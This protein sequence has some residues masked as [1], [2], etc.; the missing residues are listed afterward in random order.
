[1][2][3]NC[4]N[5]D[6]SRRLTVFNHA[7]GIAASTAMC[8]S[9]LFLTGCGDEIDE[10]AENVTA[11]MYSI[12][13]SDVPDIE[14][15]DLEPATA[16]E[17][18]PPSAAPPSPAGIANGED[19]DETAED[20]K[21]NFDDDLDELNDGLE[22]YVDDNGKFPDKLSELVDDGT[23]PGFPTPPPGKG[24]HFNKSTRQFEWIDAAEK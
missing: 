9:L 1:M 12:P 6:P 21:N 3:L 16:A 4:Q 15:P 18:A 20:I 7:L 10:S 19:E 24:L 2:K 8:G 11:G 22:E 13:D 23:I 5:T 14:I 17:A